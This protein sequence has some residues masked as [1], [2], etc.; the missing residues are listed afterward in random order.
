[1]GCIARFL[2]GGGSRAPEVGANQMNIAGEDVSV[3]H[4]MQ[5]RIRLRFRSR[6]GETDFFQQLVTLLSKISL[7]DEVDANPL[8]GSVLVRHSASLEQLAFLAAG[9]I[10]SQDL[11][12]AIG[13]PTAPRCTARH[14]PSSPMSVGLFAL[15]LLQVAR[16]RA[17]GSASEQFW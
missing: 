7:V 8:T 2:S 12:S 15:A 11:S 16:G 17:L 9:L 1:M 13:H 14:R 6:R 3:E 5:G 4:V 10:P